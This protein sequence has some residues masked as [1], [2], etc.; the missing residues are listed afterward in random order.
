LIGAIPCLEIMPTEGKFFFPKAPHET[1]KMDKNMKNQYE[2]G[3]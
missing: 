2:N 1:Q 3:A